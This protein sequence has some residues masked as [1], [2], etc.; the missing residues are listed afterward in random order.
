MEKNNY[1]VA[2]EYWEQTHAPQL[3]VI[4]LGDGGRSEILYRQYEEV[5]HLKKIVAFDRGNSVL[6]LG[7]G[8]GRWAFALA[9]LV[10]S[11]VGVDFSQSMIDAA[12]GRA[13]ALGLD[14]VTF[15]R[16]ALQDY[17]T[18]QRF[19]VIYL[20][21]VSQY[22]H[23]ADLKALLG[24]LQCALKPN[25]IVVDRSTTSVRERLVIEKSDYFSV[26]RTAAEIVAL[27]R[28]AGWTN[29]YCQPS[30]RILSFPLVMQR[31]MAGQKFAK[32]VSF[33]APFSFFLL[34]AWAAA[35]GSQFD[36]T[37]RLSEFSHDFFLFRR[38]INDGEPEYGGRL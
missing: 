12:N 29:Y 16:I 24:R 9:P 14:N 38:S 15:H 31:W 13:A 7:C 26:Y 37:G 36:P 33:T 8:N 22:L 17:A 1:Q 35:S 4:A 5:R 6:E 34:R 20:S 10:A 3:G 11:Y 2:R 19:D 28:G 27:Y 25:G 23:D 30:Y 32:L 18:D 21:G